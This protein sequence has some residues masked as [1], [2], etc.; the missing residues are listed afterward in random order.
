MTN[1]GTIQVPDE[2]AE[3]ARIIFIGEAPGVDEEREG[4]PFIGESGNLLTSVLGRNGIE[5]SSVRLA[6]LCHYRPRENKFEYLIGTEQLDSGFRGLCEYINIHRPMVLC[7]LG[8]W[9]LYFLTGKQGK[10]PGT[11]ILNWR[12]SILSCTIKGL[13]GIK[14]IPTVHPAYVSRNR[15]AYPIFDQ[16]M[17]RIVDDS[18]FS[19]LRLPQRESVVIDSS[20][21][22]KAEYYTNEILNSPKAALDIENIGTQLACVGFAPNSGL[23]ICYVWDNSF[24]IRDCVERILSSSVR[25]IC[26]FGT[27]DIE[28]L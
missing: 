2:G 19:D 27:H 1:I 6:N 22:D 17:K 7:P 16:D 24:I 13:E 12:G 3:D 18:A 9:P 14:V 11:G 8:A 20:N 21:I 10:K 25:K 15:S 5:R 4:R 23:G 28:V 26:H